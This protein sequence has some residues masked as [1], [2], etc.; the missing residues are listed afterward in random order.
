M[1]DTNHTTPRPETHH[2]DTLQFTVTDYPEVL[3]RTRDTAH[4]ARGTKTVEY[5]THLLGLTTDGVA[6]YFDEFDRALLEVVPAHSDRHDT[7]D[8]AR[9]IRD[10][11]INYQLGAP[12]RQPSIDFHTLPNG[13]T[14]SSSVVRDGDTHTHST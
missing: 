2:D 11:M 13:T 1:T 4:E 7:G 3:R 5:E 9:S 8:A 14:S 6:V 10:E 12:P